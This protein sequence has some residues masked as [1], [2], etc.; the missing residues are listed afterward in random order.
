MRH[1]PRIPAWLVYSAPTNKFATAGE[2]SQISQNTSDIA[3]KPN[4]FTDLSD[5]ASSYSGQAGKVATV[6]VGESGLDFEDA[7]DPLASMAIST[8]LLSGCEVTINA[9]PTKFD[10]AAGFAF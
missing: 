9:D 7:H 6:N 4:S 5:T 8:S 3:N 2:L 10:V 1:A